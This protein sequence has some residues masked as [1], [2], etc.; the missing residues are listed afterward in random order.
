MIRKYYVI[1]HDWEDGE[2]VPILWMHQYY[3]PKEYAVSR[4]PVA[5]IEWEE[6]EKLIKEKKVK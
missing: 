6:Y 3:G 4:I 2:A 5:V 1:Q